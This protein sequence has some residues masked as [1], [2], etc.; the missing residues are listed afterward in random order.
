[1]TIVEAYEQYKIMPQLQL[2]QLR[3]ASV[4]DVICKGMIKPPESRPIITACLLHDMG[5]IIKFDLNAF[6]EFLQPEGL[7]YWQ[8]VQNDYFAKYGMD[9]HLATKRIAQELGVSSRV[10]ELIHSIGFDKTE[11]NFF[12]DDLGRKICEYSDDRVAPQGV[13]T[14]LERCDDLE[15]RYGQKY[16]SEVDQQR[17]QRFREFAIKIEEQIFALAKIHPEDITDVTIN[18]KIDFLKSFQV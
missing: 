5:N 14:L 3:V 6:P 10:Y 15:T 18:D 13:V 2:H 4:A 11:E 17:R 16:P 12:L 1:M 9:E 7:E 8:Q